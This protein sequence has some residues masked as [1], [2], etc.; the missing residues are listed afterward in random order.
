[1]GQRSPTETLFG[2]I[3]AFI[4]ERTW[5]QAA[6]AR[7]LETRPETIRRRLGELQAGGFPLERSEEHPHVYW[8]VPKG[9]FPGALIFKAD[10][11]SEL[12]RLVARAPRGAL[13]ARV[14]GR[15]VARLS[16][17]GD[18]A[19]IEPTAVEP[20]AVSEEEE[21]WIALAEDAIS[22]KIAVKMRYF[23]ASRR[24]EAWRHASVHRVVLGPRPCFI[25]TCHTADALRRFRVS[26]V[27]DARLDRGEPYRAV[28]AAAL[29]R[30]ADESFAGFWREGPAFDC[31][32]L[33][34]EPEA[35]W[36]ARNLPDDRIARGVSTDAGT[37]FSVRTSAVD[38][39]ARFVV[40]LGDA[41]R[42][43]T[44]ELAREVEA[45]ARGALGEAVDAPPTVRRRRAA[46]RA[47]RRG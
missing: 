35:T 19:D 17:T 46:A 38:V 23:S 27:L 39:L 24:D 14:L 26:N 41:A 44:P 29:R 12:L 43:E 18:H 3:T 7:R 28:S 34:R 40:G 37:R 30:F 36:V 15:I 25:G 4:D 20:P 13:R 1:M 10:E 47:R 32:F 16:A 8:S 42:A 5:T 6:L 33:V 9:W 45:L 22:Q 21:R 11:V 2:I 31:A